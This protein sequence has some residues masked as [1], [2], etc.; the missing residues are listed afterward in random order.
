MARPF[1]AD[2]TLNG[3]VAH[4]DWLPTFAAAAGNPNIKEQRLK[5][6]ELN[7]RT[8][9]NYVDG[10]NMLDYLSG[11]VKTSPRNEFWYVNDDGEIVAARYQDW[12]VVWQENRGEAFGVWREPFVQLR[13]PLLFNL[14]RD[15]FEKVTKPGSPDFVPVPER[16]AVYDNDGTLWS[17]QPVPVQF[18]FVADRVKALAPQHPEWKDTEP[19]ASILKGDL[20]KA[21]EGGDH[22]LMEL[23]MATHTG[24]STDEFAQMVKDWIA[25]AKHPTT[26]KRFLDMTYQPMLEVLDYLRADCRTLNTA[27]SPPLWKIKPRKSAGRWS[28]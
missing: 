17:E 10:Y 28:A 20:R 9:K 21:L 8:Y 4:E 3:I 2:T 27:S 25:T 18:Y 11:K 15:P 19:F 23:F 1:P 12:K 16:I 6:V 7:G 26:G 13:I 24:M 22:G 5:G 14:R